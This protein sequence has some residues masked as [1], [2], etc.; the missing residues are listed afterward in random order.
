M[1]ENLFSPALIQR[2]RLDT[3]GTASRIHFNN[4]GASLLAS[5]VYQAIQTYQQQ[6]LA[7]GGYETEAL[8]KE[9][10]ESVYGKL[11]RLIGA[12]AGS[13]ALT[14]SATVAWQLAFVGMNFQAGDVILCGKADYASNFLAYLRLQ[15]RVAIKIEIIEDDAFGQMDL[16]AL[17]RAMKKGAK[18]LSLTHIP[19]NGGLVNPAEAAGR[20]AKQYGV[21]YLLDACQS[22]G[23]YPVEVERI[24]CDFLS[25]TGRKYL[26][27][28]RGTGFLY[29]NPDKLAYL[30]PINIDLSG[31][32]WLSE[33]SYEMRP[34]ARRL[35]SYERNRASQM[36]LGAAVDYALNL[37]ME[38]IWQR[39]RYLAEKLRVCLATLPMYSVH[40]QGLIQAGL[41]SVSHRT[42]SAQVLKSELYAQGINVS[43]IYPSSTL[44]DMSDRRLGE[45]IRVS[46]H[47]YNT[48]E[49]LERLVEV[50]ATLA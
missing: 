25:A 13:V 38:R 46:V 23:Q 41:V 6:E 7:L 16:E 5:P 4:A 39:I 20:L 30:S 21:W 14:E 45:L 35:Q 9:E 3:P 50:L 48:E 44:L 17:E 31:A 1:K 26:R 10:L 12:K 37:G 33:T 8:Y 49:E 15:Q 47:Y 18:L 42:L 24:G 40:D 27:A 11:E 22:I 36:G 34:D 43:V 19:S 2:L 29:V 28:P 32:E